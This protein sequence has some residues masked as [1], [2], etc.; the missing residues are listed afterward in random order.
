VEKRYLAL[1]HRIP[2]DRGELDTP[3]GRHPVDR[4]RFSSPWLRDGKP[5]SPHPLRGAGR[6]EDR[7]APGGGVAD[8]AHPPDPRHFAIGAGR[9][10]TTRCT[11][12]P[13]GRRE[14]PARGQ[15]GG[16]GA[17]AARVC[18][19]GKLAFA[20]PSPARGF[21]PGAPAGRSTG[22][23]ARAGIILAAMTL[24]DHVPALLRRARALLGLSPDLT[25]R[26]RGGGEAG[27]ARR[28]GAPQGLIGERAL[29]RPS[30]YAGR[31]SAHTC[32]GGGR[33][34]TSRQRR[35]FAWRRFRAGPDP[36]RRLR[37]RAG[38]ARGARCL[39]GEAV[40][41]DVSEPALAEAR[42]LGI[43]RTARSCRARASI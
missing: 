37:A 14:G 41:F 7:R 22:G 29:A 34:P 21:L 9:S 35:R 15:E 19:P 42:A 40:C 33:R 20:H 36:R 28:A 12:A 24:D 39:G 43:A 17:G 4:K 5:K 31:G 23:T 8:G 11:A 38:G 18:T 16:C 25:R 32:S 30:T 6:V 26:S 10:S 1:V 13:A 3:Y 2:P 27:G